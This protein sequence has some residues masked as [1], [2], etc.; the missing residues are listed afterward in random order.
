MDRSILLIAMQTH[1]E[2]TE[3]I[4]RWIL[5]FATRGTGRDVVNEMADEMARLPRLTLEGLAAILLARMTVDTFERLE[6]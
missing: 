5:R 6:K 2:A 3:F 1:H 4:D